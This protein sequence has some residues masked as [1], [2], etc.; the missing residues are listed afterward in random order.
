MKDFFEKLRGVKGG[1]LL[2]I[3]GMGA[4]ALLSLTGSESPQDM[5]AQERRISRTLSLIQGAGECRITLYTGEKDSAF[6]G[7]SAPTGAIILA[8]GAESIDVR[9][10]LRQAAEAL[11]GLPSDRIEIFPMEESP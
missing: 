5:T 2:L 11:L 9:L 3:L 4:L 6:S 1:M 10:R 7:G 8:Q